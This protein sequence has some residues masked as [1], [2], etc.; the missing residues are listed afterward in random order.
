[1][2]EST[3]NIVIVDDDPLF[4]GALAQALGTRLLSVTD[5]VNILEAGDFEK[6]QTILQEKSDI[7]LV[8]LD[9]AMPGVIGFSGLLTLRAEHTALPVIIVSASDDGAI[10]SRA[11]NLGASG[12]I[13][14]SAS[15]DTIRNAIDCVLKGDV[16]RPG[17]KEAMHEANEEVADV[18]ARLSTLTP[19]QAR[20]LSMVSQGL[21]N[22]QIADNLD[23]TEATVK[24]HVSAVL[25]KLKVYSRT[26]AVIQLSK[27][28]ED[29]P[30]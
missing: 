23:I 26:Q 5:E 9:L 21:L 28:G 10:I 12:F 30:K 4:R 13:P 17:G 19:Q 29:A 1:M 24:A 16:W 11:L 20:V 18:I 8:L 2:S 14:K 6:L 15:I 22:K 7:D 25:L 27:L 3:T